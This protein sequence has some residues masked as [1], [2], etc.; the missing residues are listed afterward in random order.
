MI[1]AEV[2]ADSVSVSSGIR[3]T[4]MALC[5]PK[6]IHGELM[7][8]RVFS[9]NARS[10]RAV[11]VA[12]VLREVATE[13]VEPILWGSNKPGMQSSEELSG[14]A[15]LNV[16]DGWRRLAKHVAAEC[17]ALAEDGLHKQWA[18]RPLEPF[19]H[20][21]TLVTSTYWRNF[22]QLR[23]HPDA[24]PEMKALAD[25]MH[26][27]HLASTPAE[28][29]AGEWHLPYVDLDTR[30]QVR[31]AARTNKHAESDMLLKVSTA[32]CARVSY[33]TFENR[34]PTTEEDLALFERLMGAQPLHASPAEH[35]ATPA[36][37][38]LRGGDLTRIDRGLWGNLYGWV[39][40]RKTL[41]GE[42]GESAQ[43]EIPGV[44]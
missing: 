38:F 30:E 42:S 6:Y 19:T 2:I 22:Y 37:T 8:H 44:L 32:R 40:F 39:Q 18:N 7:T 31:Q 26:E 11:P 21:F 17:A 14:Y 12:K 20:I 43:C 16:R 9:R 1:T 5:Y 15:L 34:V 29:C 36:Q 25:A 35:Q 13:P 23:R 33:R 28:V 24:Q 27:A 10:S 3:I 41:P 4:T